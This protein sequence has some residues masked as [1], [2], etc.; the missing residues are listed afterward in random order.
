MTLEPHKSETKTS[1]AP[2]VVLLKRSLTLPLNVIVSP[3]IK[4]IQKGVQSLQVG[5]TT[6][7]DA[8]V[9]FPQINFECN[10]LFD[11]IKWGGGKH[12][13]SPAHD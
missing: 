7:S 13:R 8:Q 6:L 2:S 11:A 4:L 5:L 9:L 10:M 3:Q 1:L 12:P